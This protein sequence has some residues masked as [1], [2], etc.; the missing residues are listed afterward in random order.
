M[1]SDSRIK[2]E[3]EA[4]FVNS[5]YSMD[6][7][8]GEL[9]DSIEQ[10]SQSAFPVMIIGERGTGKE[11]ISQALYTKSPLQANPLVIIDCSQLTDKGVELSDESL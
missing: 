6:G 9:S 11:L 3:A 1:E 8:M 7:V 10:I 4:Q 5:F 2:K